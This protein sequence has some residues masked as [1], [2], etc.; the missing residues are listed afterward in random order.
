MR[1]K[2][3]ETLER[4]IDIYDFEGLD[5]DETG[6]IIDMI[7]DLCEAEKDLYSACYYKSLCNGEGAVE[8]KDVVKK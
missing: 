4:E 7:K 6:N 8:A 1:E 5:T 2:L 3:I